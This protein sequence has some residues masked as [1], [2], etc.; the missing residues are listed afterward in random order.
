MVGFDESGFPFFFGDGINECVYDGGEG[1]RGFHVRAG[2][3][4]CS[5]FQ[6]LSPR[7]CTE[8]GVPPL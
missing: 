6:F 5:K 3:Q 2:K 8:M 7:A 1:A 4:K